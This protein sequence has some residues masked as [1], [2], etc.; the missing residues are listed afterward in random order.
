[1]NPTPE[2]FPADA[3]VERITPDGNAWCWVHV[4]A[5]RAVRL[6]TR[7]VIDLGI[8]VGSSWTVELA[9]RAHE[10]SLVD[11]AV[12]GLRKWLHARPRSSAEASD[13]IAKDDLDPQL[14]Q[15]AIDRLVASG[16]INDAG[17]AE[18]ERHAAG[19]RGDSAERLTERLKSRGLGDAI[20]HQSP[21]EPPSSSAIE[22]ARRRAES[23]RPDLAWNIK[24][25]RLSGWLA[26]R[27][28]SEDDS[29]HAVRTVLG[30]PPAR[31]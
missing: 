14:A 26:S 4:G 3:A 18:L 25:R 8:T 23:F 7:T 19:R 17:V 31:D 20:A 6:H 2:L 24:A 13:R 15:Q 10:A 30:E 12:S 16:E 29:T 11:H 21:D 22:I 9:T 5:R 1:M 27:G 28:F